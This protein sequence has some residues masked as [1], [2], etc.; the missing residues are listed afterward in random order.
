MPKKKGDFIIPLEEFL[1]AGAHFGHQ[2]RR[3]NPKMKQYLHTV[4]GGVHIFDLVKTAE[5]LKAASEYVSDLLSDGGTIIFV[6][7][8]R[9][10]QEIVKEEA[11]KCGAFFVT[12]RWLGGTI[13]N[14]GQIGKSI[15]RLEEMREKREAGEYD[16]YTKKENV[17]INRE[18]EKLTRFLGGLVGLRKIPDAIFVV[19]VVR[20]IAAVKEAKLRGVKVVAILDSNADPDMADYVIPA[21]DDAVRSIKLIVTK[22]SE[23]VSEGKALKEKGGIKKKTGRVSGKRANVETKNK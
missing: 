5:G 21:N 22:I 1:E 2:A 15:R 6:G 18:I 19:D 23:A 13:T 17:L 4:R 11:Q 12:E 14:W 8:K 10:A 9:Q 7:T 16:K 20:E 3:W